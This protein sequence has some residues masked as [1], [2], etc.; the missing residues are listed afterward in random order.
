MHE[1]YPFESE[2]LETLKQ[3]SFIEDIVRASNRNS[4]MGADRA[5]GEQRY[6]DFKSCCDGSLSVFL[7]HNAELDF[8]N[9]TLP[10]VSI[11]S[12]RTSLDDRNYITY[13]ADQWLLMD[14]VGVEM[15]TTL[16][17]MYRPSEVPPLQYHALGHV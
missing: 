8:L 7:P 11:Q 12:V 4:L 13:R 9:S 16:L 17:E 14:F 2:I 15:G 10:L 5:A 1:F 3:N 6:F